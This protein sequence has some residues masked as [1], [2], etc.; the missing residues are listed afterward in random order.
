[1]IHT[2]VLRRRG[3]ASHRVLA[4]TSVVRRCSLLD[5]LSHFRQRC[6][7]SASLIAR[8]LRIVIASDEDLRLAANSSFHRVH[9]AFD[10]ST[11]L[12]VRVLSV[13]LAS[14]SLEPDAWDGLT[15]LLAQA[16]DLVAS[17]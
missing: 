7:A 13:L 15:L 17:L 5:N 16:F 8:V 3:R 12:P 11:L 9:T 4:G 2:V 6:I 1:L 10:E 14:V